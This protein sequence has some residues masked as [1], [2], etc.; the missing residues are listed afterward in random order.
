MADE[1][2]PDRPEDEPSPP[3]QGEPKPAADSGDQARDAAPSDPI[4]QHGLFEETPVEAE[5]PEPE[6]LPEPPALAPIIE[7]EPPVFASESVPEADTPPEPAEPEIFAA[8][9]AERT[10]EP[11]A[12]AE[13]DVFAAESAERAA[14]PPAPAEPEVFAAE[15]AEPA[16][17][18]PAPVEPE[19]VAAEEAPSPEPAAPEPTAPQ[20]ERELPSGY[21]RAA[22]DP[23]EPD[24]EPDTSF[25]GRL[26]ERWRAFEARIEPSLFRFW[27]Q[28]RAVGRE[29]VSR[30][31]QVRHPK[32]VREAAVW[33]GWAASGALTPWVHSTASVSATSV[34]AIAKGPQRFIVFASLRPRVA[35]ARAAVSDK[36]W[37]PASPGRVRSARV[38]DG[39]NALFALSA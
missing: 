38:A 2:D 16:E 12:P 34:G 15:P 29:A 30:A 4:D 28:T 24:T 6:A 39:I 20:A 32:T 22:G 26:A 8:E 31:R 23:D 27:G 3:A 33:G 17:E 19:G 14:E 5:P 25:F 9:P 13:P 18:P 1:N 7:P 35:E 21:F 36:S 37:P 10:A 11:P